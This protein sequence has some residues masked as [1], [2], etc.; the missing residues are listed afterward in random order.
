MSEIFS[1]KVENGGAVVAR[2]AAAPGGYRKGN[3]IMNAV[4]NVG[5]LLE[6]IHR[7]GWKGFSEAGAHCHTGS[8]NFTKLLRGEIPRLDV[9]FR[10]ARG[11]DISMQDLILYEPEQDKTLVE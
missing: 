5:L 1:M 11:L 4:V 2:V 6:A 3:L 10:I 7:K 8:K 9:L